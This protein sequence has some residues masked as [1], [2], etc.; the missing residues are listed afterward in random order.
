[1]F[2]GSFS[3]GKIGLES[4]VV[5]DHVQPG[6]AAPKAWVLFLL[7]ACA[8]LV[9]AALY[10]VV[11]VVVPTAGLPTS[12]TWIFGAAFTVPLA[13]LLCLSSALG[14]LVGHVVSE[15]ST[16]G[17]V[18]GG[19]IGGGL[20]VALIAGVGFAPAGIA[21]FAV[22]AVVQSVVLAIAYWSTRSRVLP[23]EDHPNP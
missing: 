18:V 3:A 5:E 7:S 23:A 6:P 15:R 11:F 10:V 22:A 12:V 16:V 19:L 14:A 20:G 8:G 4:E 9:V 1:M 21:F 17:V 13:L 2:N